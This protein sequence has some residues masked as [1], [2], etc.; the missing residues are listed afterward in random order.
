MSVKSHIQLPISIIDSFSHK[1]L[2]S[3]EN[4]FKNKANFVYVLPFN[5]FNVKS[6]RTNEYGSEF[7]YFSDD[8]EELLSNKYESPLGSTRKKDY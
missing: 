1:E 3:G 2:V 4:G 6:I 7:G 8:V 5:S